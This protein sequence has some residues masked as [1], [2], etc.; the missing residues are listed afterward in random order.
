[1]SSTL[2]FKISSERP[3]RFGLQRSTF[4]Q[5]R[6]TGHP[7]V[8]FISAPDGLHLQYGGK[9][10][11]GRP[12]NFAGKSYGLIA[13]FLLQLFCVA[14]LLADATVDILGLEQQPE[15]G[16]NHVLEYLV[17]MALIFSLA[18]TGR[19]V[20]RLMIRNRNV[21]D[22]LKAASGKFSEIMDQHFDDWELTFSERDVAMLAIKRFGHRR[23]CKPAQYQRGDR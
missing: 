20:Y 16:E 8:V 2:Q 9:S 6:C 13:L 4:M 5:D 10:V 23:D 17:V 7:I 19:Q 18:A 21:E 15:Y 12:L 11:G 1:M 14:F 3:V 22:Q